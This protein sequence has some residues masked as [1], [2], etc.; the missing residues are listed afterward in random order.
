MAAVSR[1]PHGKDMVQ[2]LHEGVG[3]AG[4][5]KLSIVVQDVDPL[6]LQGLDLNAALVPRLLVAMVPH[7]GHLALIDV[8]V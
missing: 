6:G 8:G 4:S 1:V 7:V 2:L 5:P 3:P